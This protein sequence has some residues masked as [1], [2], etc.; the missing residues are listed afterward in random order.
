MKILFLLAT[1]A[2]LST[3]S[4]AV[5]P[6][7]P[8]IC[9]KI[10]RNASPGGVLIDEDGAES[11][12][13]IN[14]GDYPVPNHENVDVYFLKTRYR[15]LI[16]PKRLKVHWCKSEECLVL[17]PVAGQCANSNLFE[18]SWAIRIRADEIRPYT[19]G[20]KGVAPSPSGGLNLGGGLRFDD[21]TQM[22]EVDV[23]THSDTSIVGRLVL[24]EPR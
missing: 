2:A 1:T 3:T 5:P 12:G 8:E 24:P 6:V 19:L 4:L 16:W 9:A 10:A 7:K 18:V 15:L 23:V 13:P 14:I 20:T 21:P 11:P 17:K 22:E